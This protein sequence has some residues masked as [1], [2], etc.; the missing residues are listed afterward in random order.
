MSDVVIRVALRSEAIDAG[1]LVDEVGRPEAGATAL[2][3]GTARNHSEGKT[4][5]THLEYEAYAEHVEAALA[6]IAGEAAERWPVLSILVEH[7]TGRVAVGEPSVA[8][9]VSSAH[10]GDAFEAARYVIDELKGR[11]P[12]WKREHWPG[13]AEWV[14]G[15]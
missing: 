11:A 6:T 1:A 5:V 2:F 7:R 12:I 15:A 3:L 13:G 14:E 8:V 4:D 10:R 9:A